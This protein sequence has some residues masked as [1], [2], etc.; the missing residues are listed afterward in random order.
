M[1]ETKQYCVVV[2]L[3]TW[4]NDEETAIEQVTSVRVLFPRKARW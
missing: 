4:A 3:Y 2:K 1:S